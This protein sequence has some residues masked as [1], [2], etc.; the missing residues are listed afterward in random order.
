LKTQSHRR[1]G[2]DYSLACFRYIDVEHLLACD[3]LQVGFGTERCDEP[4]KCEKMTSNR[5]A[6]GIPDSRHAILAVR[7]YCVVSLRSLV[8]SKLAAHL[9]DCRT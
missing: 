4:A 9:R 5:G 3:P 2:V 7:Q 1:S 6:D 8:G